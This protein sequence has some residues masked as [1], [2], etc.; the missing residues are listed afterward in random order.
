MHIYIDANVFVTFFDISQDALAELEK[1]AVLLK[2]G[3]ATLWLPNQTRREFWKNRE[4]GITKIMADFS[5]HNL[6]GKAPLLVREDERYHELKDAAN[7]LEKVR[8]D[9]V[10]RIQQQLADEATLA[11][12]MI[13][14]LFEISNGIDTDNEAI[15]QKAHRRSLCH[16]PPG[17]SDDIGDRIAWE[18][19]LDALPDGAKLNLITD[20]GDFESDLLPGQPRSYLKAEWRQKKNG[21]LT[22]W[23]RI[24]QFIAA[25]FPEADS[26]I[27]FERGLKVEALRTSPNFAATHAAIAELAGQRG[28]SDVQC[29][30]IVEALLSNSQVHWIKDDDDVKGFFS[31]FL[32]KNKGQIEDELHKQAITLFEEK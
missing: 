22:L 4:K 16:I 31:D 6:L 21:T 10:K 8:S 7:T 2:S 24:S 29:R 23:K 20:D 32:K 30:H 25:H 1:L 5:N 11:D 27:D 3:K 28:F 15:F 14:K 17:K 26:T 12:Q 19:L 18:A 9:I 13:K